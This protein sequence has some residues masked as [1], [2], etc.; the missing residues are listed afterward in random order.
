MSLL[1]CSV[2]VVLTAS[3]S[4][5]GLLIERL[6]RLCKSKHAVLIALRSSYA[7]EQMGPKVP[8]SK[9][10]RKTAKYEGFF[11]SLHVY[12]KPNL[13]L[14]YREH[15]SARRLSSPEKIM[16]LRVNNL[17]LFSFGI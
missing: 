8:N 5:R 1:L 13:F 15:F 12:R 2:R 11:P 10:L 9:L 14:S 16:D 6:G 17:L 4:K 3:V 7:G